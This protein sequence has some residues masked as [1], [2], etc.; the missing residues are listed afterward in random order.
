MAECFNKEPK[1]EKSLG[2][3]VPNAELQNGRAAMIG[4]VGACPSPPVHLSHWH[5]QWPGLFL[6]AATHALTSQPSPSQHHNTCGYTQALI[7]L[8]EGGSGTAFFI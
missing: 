4:L 3:F 5:Q 7:L 8:L 1:K 6:A 2:P